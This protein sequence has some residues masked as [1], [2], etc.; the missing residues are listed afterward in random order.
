MLEGV[1]VPEHRIITTSLKICLPISKTKTNKQNL[2]LL[3]V[4][5]SSG[6]NEI[7]LFYILLAICFFPRLYFLF[8]YFIVFFPIPFSLHICLSHNHQTAVHVHESFFLF[9]QSFHPLPSLPQWSSCSLSMSMSLYWLLVQFVHQIS[10]MREIIWY[11]SFSDWLISLS[12]MF[13]R[14]HNVLFQPDNL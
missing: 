9:A 13:S 7:K 5:I 2:S 1:C 6:I 4:L 11:L 12:I 10:H 14:I 8:I 3:K